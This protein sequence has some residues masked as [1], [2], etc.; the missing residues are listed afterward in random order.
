MASSTKG[1]TVPKVS[2]LLDIRLFAAIIFYTFYFYQ[3]S[4][5]NVSFHKILDLL[6][7]KELLKILPWENVKITCPRK[8]LKDENQCARIQ[9]CNDLAY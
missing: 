5:V 9:E 3:N 8:L 6:S 1:K 2:Q 4:F 7:F